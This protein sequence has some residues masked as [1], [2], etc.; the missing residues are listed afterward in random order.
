MRRKTRKRRSAAACCDW[1]ASAVL[2]AMLAVWFFTGCRHA[3]LRHLT[4]GLTFLYLFVVRIIVNRNRTGC[5][6]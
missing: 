4:L 6:E 1:I 3:W 2:L 5:G